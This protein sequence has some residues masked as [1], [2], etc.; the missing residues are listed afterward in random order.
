MKSLTP[1]MIEKA[2]AAKSAE[3]LLEL[4]K[5]NGVE[6]TADEAATY[7]AQLNP[8][9]GE[10]DDDDL[11]NVAGGAGGCD[12]K[13]EVPDMIRVTSG[14]TCKHCGGTEGYVGMATYGGPL[15]VRCNK[16]HTG[17]AFFPECTYEVIG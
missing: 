4:A 1:E 3:E 12:S 8:K 14:Q 17:F 6:M 11:D 9:S 13:T 7:F 10:L 16:C 5:A 15:E 2:K